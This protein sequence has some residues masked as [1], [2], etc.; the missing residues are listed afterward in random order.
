MGGPGFRRGG[1]GRIIHQMFV[2]F[3]SVQVRFTFSLCYF[4]SLIVFPFQRSAFGSENHRLVRNVEDQEVI[5]VSE[6]ISLFVVP[7]VQI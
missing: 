3:V 4:A 1:L 5:K 7:L 2:L 6:V